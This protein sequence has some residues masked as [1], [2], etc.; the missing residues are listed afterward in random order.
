M[1]IGPQPARKEAQNLMLPRERLLRSL[2]R[3]PTDRAPMDLAGTSVTGIT[4]GAYE[5]LKKRLGVQ[6]ETRVCH[7]MMQL[8]RVDEAVLQKLGI[9]T[10]SVEMRG[11]KTW[12]DI[13]FPDGSYQDEWGVVRARPKSSHYYDLVKSPLAGENV[14][15]EH[16]AAFKWPDPDAQ[17]RCV[18]VAA[19]AAALRKTGYAICTSLHAGFITN[20]QYMR[21]FQDWFMDVAANQDLLVAIL[22]KNLDIRLEII[23]PYLAALGDNV[24]VVMV[25]DDLATSKA[26]MFSLAAYRDLMKP[27]QK[28]L[29][30]FIRRRTRAKIMYHCCGSVYPFLPDL[31]DLDIDIINPVQVSAANMDTKRLKAEWGR[32]FAFWGGID[33]HRVLPLGSPADVKAEVKRRFADL[34]PSGYVLNAVHNLQPDVPPENIVAMYEQVTGDR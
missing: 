14:T 32:R 19:E 31:A 33:T 10:R 22:R 13:E 17:S 29:F 5:R 15:L 21:G 25:G 9:D 24:D 6:S 20:S 11:A 16:V 4:A 28:Q 2:N 30:A 1:A 7:R 18:G 26:P 34:G 3:Q 27:L 8:V 23:G 12:R